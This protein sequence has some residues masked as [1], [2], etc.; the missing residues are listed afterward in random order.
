MKIQ[1]EI[2]LPGDKSISHRAALFSALGKEKTKFENFPSGADCLATLSCLKKLGVYWELDRNTLHLQGVGRFGLKKPAQILDVKNSGTTIRL[3]SGILAAQPFESHITGDQHLI[4]RPMERIITP[5]R[6]MGANISA[7]AD[8]FPPLRF[9][10]VGHLNAIEYRLPVASA[11]VKSSILLAGLYAQGTTSVIESI[12]TRDHTER[13]LNLPHKALEDG[14]YKISSNSNIEID[15]LSMYIP[16]DFSSASFFVAA[17]LLLPGS[18]CVVRNVSLNPSRSGLLHVLEKMGAHIDITIKQDE[19]EPMGDLQVRY[20]PLK[21]CKLAG[22]II[23]NIIDEIPILSILA[24][25]AEGTFTIRDAG[26]LRVKESDRI[27]TICR[28]LRR[29]GVSIEELND[30]F[31]LEGPQTVKGG[32]VITGDDHRIAMAFAVAGLLTKERII[33]DNPGC[34][35]VSFPGFWQELK[36]L[37]G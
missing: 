34:V 20:Q 15:D 13:M 16:G 6:K 1:G 5:L 11:Q 9:E 24:L 4:R 8:Q 25:Q 35:D 10:P 2:Y 3:L 14:R 36:R 37:S 26:E 32:S 19:P 7:E 17:A 28:N 23:P 31:V 30:G 33:M 27:R 18:E 12:A 29:L 22:S 21:N